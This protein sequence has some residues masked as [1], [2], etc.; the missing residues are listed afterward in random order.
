MSI[1]TVNVN[2]VIRSESIGIKDA[3]FVRTHKPDNV[4]LVGVSGVPLLERWNL[5]LL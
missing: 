3:A 4:S 5:G 2:W 1:P